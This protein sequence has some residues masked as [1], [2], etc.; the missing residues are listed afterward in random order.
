MVE[1]MTISKIELQQHYLDTTYSV[2]ISNKKCDI[3]IGKLLPPAIQEVINKEKFAAVLTAWNPRSQP[4]S[5]V[6]NKSRNIEL[7]SKLKE[8]EVFDALGQGNDLEW[9]AEESFFI[10]GISKEQVEVFAI[11]YEQYA[12]VWLEANKEVSLIFTNIWHL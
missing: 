6:E 7:N 1:L 3:R 5:L 9:L 10:V 8:Y 11:E 12:Y 2:F 4:L